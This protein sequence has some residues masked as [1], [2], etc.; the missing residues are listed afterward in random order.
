LNQQF[1]LPNRAVAL[2]SPSS[3]SAAFGFQLRPS[4]QEFAASDMG[5]NGQFCTAK[6]LNRACRLGGL[7]CAKTKSDSKAPGEQF[8]LSESVAGF[9]RQT[10]D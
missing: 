6:I 1:L 9:D 7:G 8:E 10:V 2:P 4:K 3:G 5:A